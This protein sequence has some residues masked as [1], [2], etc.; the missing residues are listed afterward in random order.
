MY[1]FEGAHPFPEKGWACLGKRESQERWI[2]VGL[3]RLYCPQSRQQVMKYKQGNDQLNTH[4]DRFLIGLF[5]FS[6]SSLVRT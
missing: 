1:G 2:R 5:V 4:E 6:L 3:T